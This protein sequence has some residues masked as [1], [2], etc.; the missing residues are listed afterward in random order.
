MSKTI[1]K[2]LVGDCDV[3][4]YVI[5]SVITCFTSFYLESASYMLSIISE[6]C[7]KKVEMVE[8]NW[9]I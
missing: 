8:S 3:P 5:D 9:K 4:V 1:E 6:N 2:D 7:P